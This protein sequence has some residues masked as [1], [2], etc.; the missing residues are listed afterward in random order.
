MTVHDR[1]L[2]VSVAQQFHFQL[3]EV[4]VWSRM[5]LVHKKHPLYKSSLLKSSS[6][7]QD[8][9]ELKASSIEKN[10]YVVSEC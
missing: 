3:D 7:E 4:A 6:V 9:E 1:T 2:Q 8:P 10:K 5:I